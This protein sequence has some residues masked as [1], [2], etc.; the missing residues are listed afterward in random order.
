MS[1]TNSSNPLLPEP[2]DK[3]LM[4]I[5]T[6]LQE[7]NLTKISIGKSFMN[8]LETPYSSTHS[9][10]LGISPTSDLEEMIMDKSNLG[11]K[12]HYKNNKLVVTSNNNKDDNSINLSMEELAWIYQPWEYS[13]IIKLL[14]RKMTHVYLKSKL[15]SLWRTSGEILLIDLGHDYYIVK[16]LQE[17]NFHKVLQNGP[18]FVNGFFLSVKK[19]QP[20]FVVS[21]AKE[22]S[23]AIWIR[24]P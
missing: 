17:V 12:D 22:R 3:N 2:P 19:W 9:K 23:T 13:I 5:D 1:H 8:V 10:N 11:V 7:D 18:W 15:K 20:N 14:G 24:L 4:E 21:T 6:S 16:F